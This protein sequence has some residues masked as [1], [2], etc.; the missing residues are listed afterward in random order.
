MDTEN[1]LINPLF[2]KVLFL[3][4]HLSVNKKIEMETITSVKSIVI[5]YFLICK[6]PLKSSLICSWVSDYNGAI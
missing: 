3:K 4:V 5:L 6:Y 1:V 2:N